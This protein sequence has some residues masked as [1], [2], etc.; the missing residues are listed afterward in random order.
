MS[1]KGNRRSVG[2]TLTT[3]QRTAE[4][5]ATCYDELPPLNSSATAELNGDAALRATLRDFQA[6]ALPNVPISR[7]CL[8]TL[9]YV[10]FSAFPKLRFINLVCENSTLPWVRLQ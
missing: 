4:S 10:S 5:S 6:S 1:T 8:S 2:I 9:S 7:E 3:T